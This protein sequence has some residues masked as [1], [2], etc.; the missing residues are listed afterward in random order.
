MDEARQPSGSGDMER[1]RAARRK[2][3]RAAQ[4]VTLDKMST[5]DC[6]VK[7]LSAIGAL[8]TAPSLQD[9]PDRFYLRAPGQMR[10]VPCR[11]VRK[12]L[13]SVVIIFEAE[14]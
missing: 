1:R 6:T 9:I 8:I 10:L 5:F 7:N 2:V 14:G 11:L 13:T 12:S 4:I 3:L